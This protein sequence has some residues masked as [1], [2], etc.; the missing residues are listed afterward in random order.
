MGKI[1]ITGGTVFVSRCFAEWFVRRGDEVYVLNR[2]TRQQV[3]GVNL[4]KADR[5]DLGD[6]LKGI[7]FDAVIDVNA[8]NADDV[9]ELHR[10]LG[11]FGQYILIS[12]SAVYP[13]NGRQPFT[14]ETPVGPNAVWKQYGTDKIAAE[15]TIAGLVPEA[16][17]IRP[18]YL[19]GPMNNLYREAFVFD[20]AR[21]GR[22]FYLPGNGEMKL[23]FYHV[24]DLCRLTEKVICR[25]PD[26]HI[27]NAGNPRSVS[28]REWVGKC[29]AC[30]GRTPEF[31]YVYHEPEQRKY[32]SFYDYEYYLDV[33]KQTAICPETTDLDDGLHESAEWYFAHEADIIK[34]P[35]TEYIDQVIRS[36]L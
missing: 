10:A 29:Y 32:F 25:K 31:A 6:Q 18:P 1:L 36:R 20:C 19:Y 35:Y 22:T 13:D 11:I 12:S 9:K 33:R 8:Y 34:R 4:I 16:Y 2:N 26:T 23:Q 17:I 14:E 5:H 15:Q 28:V 27:F 24:R 3:E 21:A 7:C 30:L